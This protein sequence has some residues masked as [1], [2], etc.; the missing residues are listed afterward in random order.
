M[1]A[2]SA[3]QASEARQGA[4]ALHADDIQIPLT[5]RTYVIGSAERTS[6]A[7]KNTARVQTTLLDADCVAA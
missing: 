1:S 2:S 6:F 5:K 3:K 4:A 7:R